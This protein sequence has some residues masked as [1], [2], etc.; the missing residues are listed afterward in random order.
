MNIDISRLGGEFSG[1]ASTRSKPD[2]NIE[3]SRL[4]MEFSGETSV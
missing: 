1:L 3:I 4:G 2:T